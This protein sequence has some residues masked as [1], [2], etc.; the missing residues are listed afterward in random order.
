M[1]L[2]TIPAKQELINILGT[3]LYDVWTV[4]CLS[5]ETHYDMEKSWSTGGKQWTYEY[6][7]RKGGKTLCALYIKEHAIGCLIIYGKQEQAVFE[8]QCDTFPEQIQTLYRETQA[9][10]DG[11]WLMIPVQDTAVFTYIVRLLYMKRKPNRKAMI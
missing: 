1:K 2:D 8:A 10:H 7:Y 11:K 3:A 4:L 9:Y 6:K 5:I